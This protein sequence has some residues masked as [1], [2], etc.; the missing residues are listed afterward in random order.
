MV[1]ISTHGAGGAIPGIVCALYEAC[2]DEEALS[3]VLRDIVRRFGCHFGMIT[4]M[5][6]APPGYVLKAYTG[7]TVE[8][9][10]LFESRFG[11]PDTNPWIRSA[12]GFRPGTV[13]EESRLPG[14]GEI[15]DTAFWKELIR[16]IDGERFLGAVTH[17]EPNLVS[18]LSVY[19]SERQ[20]PFGERE[21]RSFAA[22]LP[23]LRRTAA[24][25]SR[26]SRQ[27]AGR[28][29]ALAA[30]HS[31]ATATLLVDER[32]RITFANREAED[33]LAERD[34]FALSR[35]ALRC[36]SPDDDARLKAAIAR[37]VET[38][39]GRAGS[40]GANLLVQRPSGGSSLQV[41]VAPLRSG[42][43]GA[44]VFVG[45]PEREPAGAAGALRE[46]FGLT[47]REAIVALSLC[48]GDSLPEIAQAL[49]VS[50]N[51]VRTHLARALAAVGARRQTDLVRLLLA[52]PAVRRSVEPE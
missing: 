38:A 28:D 15:G 2:F 51:T 41:V 27:L 35:G 17:T 26:L 22:L 33:L 6:L 50:H 18:H 37:A 42:G 12:M 1:R 19:R 30:L 48:R 44:V 29:A 24:M 21:R 32:G 9:Q 11:G 4:D 13:I 5:R 23:H 40:A 43:A 34:G 49:C 39:S 36:Q 7:V 52:I 3:G 10:R 25:R 8:A 45:D 47:E 46:M 14:K 16:P 31:L 20:R